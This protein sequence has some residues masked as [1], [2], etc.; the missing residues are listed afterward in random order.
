[1]EGV[2]YSHVSVFPKPTAAEAGDSCHVSLPCALLRP[3]YRY[4]C[5]GTADSVRA[6]SPG[7]SPLAWSLH[8]YQ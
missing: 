1:M 5:L 3:S 7:Q 8:L 2:A 6:A 4:V